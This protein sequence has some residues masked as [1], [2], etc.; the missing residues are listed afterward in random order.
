MIRSQ[1]VF[2]CLTL[3]MLGWIG[4]V[5]CADEPL[6]SAPYSV[7]LPPPS[8]NAFGVSV[9]FGPSD[10]LMY[11]WDGGQVLRQDAPMS[12]SFTSIGNV[13]SGNA[14][15]GPLAFSRDGSQ[16][17]AGNGAGGLLGGA[18]RDWYSPFRPPAA[19]ATRRPAPCCITTR[20]WPLR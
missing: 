17:L 7:M 18:T 12:S 19:A 8:T 1:F 10:G 4:S 16:L 14:D 6:P 5:A 9:A 2:R 11:V 20:F 13:G 15:A 3:V